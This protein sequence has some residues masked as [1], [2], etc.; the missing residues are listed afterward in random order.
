MRL[1]AILL[2][3]ISFYSSV[4]GTAPSEG[5][6]RNPAMIS[7]RRHGV[8]I[9][10]NAREGQYC[11]LHHAMATFPP[12]RRCSQASARYHGCPREPSC[13][14]NPRPLLIA[15]ACRPLVLG[16]MQQKRSL[17][18]R[19]KNGLVTSIHLQISPLQ[20][21]IPS[22]PW[23]PTSPASESSLRRAWR[24]PRS[25]ILLKNI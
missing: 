5:V 2:S 15:V 3:L 19:H 21:A 4:H 16:V 6:V 24:S 13:C 12:K 22:P 18:R 11:A 7:V 17:D 8:S 14:A 20:L 23:H 9:L 1:R 25:R 10:P